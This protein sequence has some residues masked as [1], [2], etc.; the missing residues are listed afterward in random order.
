MAACPQT[1]MRVASVDD[2]GHADRHGRRQVGP[3]RANP[4]LRGAGGH[5]AVIVAEPRVSEIA[6]ACSVSEATWSD[7]YL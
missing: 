6:E 3:T 5:V 2:T 7:G 4:L 1:P